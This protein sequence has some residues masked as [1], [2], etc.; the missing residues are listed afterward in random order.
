ME[1]SNT[2]EKDYAEYCSRNKSFSRID[3]NPFNNRIFT[4]S[5]FLRI[6]F[7]YKTLYFCV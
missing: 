4:W 3:L 6:A 7:V 2:T 5:L 1:L